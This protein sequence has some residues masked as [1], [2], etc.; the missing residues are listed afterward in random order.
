MVTFQ[1]LAQQLEALGVGQ[2]KLLMTHVSL[3]KT[4]PFEGGGATLLDAILQTLKPDGT[5]L[6]VLSASDRPLSTH[7][8]RRHTRR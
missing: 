2:Q 3:R 8:P 4:G 6:M 7:S 5:L 1:K